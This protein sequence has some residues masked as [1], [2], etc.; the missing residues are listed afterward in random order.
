MMSEK[1]HFVFVPGAWHSPAFYDPVIAELSKLGHTSD[2]V[3]LH[4]NASPPVE[5]IGPDA[6]AVV[7]KLAPLM[8]GER[9]VVLCLHSYGGVVGTEAV[10]RL[11]EQRAA[12]GKS[13]GRLKRVVFIAAFAPLAGE[14]L[15]SIADSCPPEINP[16]PL[17][18]MSVEASLT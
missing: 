7:S 13:M 2:T 3:S 18:C 1:T 4:V 14:S 9:G 10:G 12:A 6:E 16:G 11:S 17:S 8:D 15:F 5:S